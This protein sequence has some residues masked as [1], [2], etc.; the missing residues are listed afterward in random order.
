MTH[1]TLKSQAVI[2]MNPLNG[3]DIIIFANSDRQRVQG[4]YGGIEVGH[5]TTNG[6][7]IGQRLR[8][9]HVARRDGPALSLSGLRLETYFFVRQPSA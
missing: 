9:R 7:G 8:C 1:G 4:E 3:A 6:G 2:G 5:L